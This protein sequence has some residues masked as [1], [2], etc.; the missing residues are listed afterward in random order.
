MNEAMSLASVPLGGGEVILRLLLATLLGAIIGAEREYTHRPAGIRTHMLVALGAC[1]VMITGEMI[2]GLY[3]PLG[4]SPDPARMAAQVI[5][6]VGFLGAGTILREG[7]SIRGLT[8]AASV[9]AVACL[10]VAVGA[11]FY[12]VG[13]AGAVL[14][15]ITLV[16]VERLQK[17]F[18]QGR[19]V[20]YSF[21]LTVLN[22]PEVLDQV[23]LLAQQTD[24]TLTFISVD[25]QQEHAEVQYNIRFSQRNFREKAHAFFTPLKENPDV[26]GIKIEG[27]A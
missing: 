8:T 10:S 19:L 13:I 20:R 4:A 3:L 21:C 12:I 25:V 5:A 24:A 26:I 9:W 11:G 15:M 7:S 18:L 27:G 14:M 6:G 22:V 17:R 2:F 16:A 1:A 23:N